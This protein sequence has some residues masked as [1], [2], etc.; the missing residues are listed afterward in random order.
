MFDEQ[1]R[2][3]ELAD[4]GSGVR[5]LTFANPPHNGFGT[6]LS[7]QVSAALDEAA[8]DPQARVLIV[9]GHGRIFCAGADIAEMRSGETDPKGPLNEVCLR[10]GSLP[11]PVIAQINGAAAGGGLE[12]A[13]ACD[14]RFATE[15]ATFTASPVN[16]GLIAGWHRLPRLIGTARATEL[17]L[18]GSPFLA[19]EADKWGLVTV[20]GDRDQLE[21]KVRAVATRIATRAPLAVREMTAALRMSLDTDPETAA[22]HQESV[23]SRLADS[24][25]HVEA[26]S[27]FLDKRPPRFRGE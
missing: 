11:I 14:L 8:A 21:E 15:S 12:I 16:M 18:T 26:V 3:V 17:L 13:I 24:K 4:L 22:R 10:I 9:T 23:L 1:G 6:R 2:G 20:A 19:A 27:A 25:D 7:G 5:R